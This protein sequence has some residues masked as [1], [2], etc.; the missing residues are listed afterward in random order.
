VEGDRQAGRR[1]GEPAEAAKDVGTVSAQRAVFE[2]QVDAVEAADRAADFL[3]V[4]IAELAHP[5]MRIAQQILIEVK[6][7]DVERI[8]ELPPQR[9]R[10][11]GDAA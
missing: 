1:L 10:I 11:G 4:T 7:G 8:V 9:R 3:D 6:D 2:L 5:A